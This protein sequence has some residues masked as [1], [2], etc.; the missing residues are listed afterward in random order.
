MM[1]RLM[2]TALAALCLGASV[3]PAMSIASETLQAS[4][5]VALNDLFAKQWVTAGSDGL[6]RGTVRELTGDG[7]RT[8]AKVD[9]AL[10][11][12]GNVAYSTK[13]D[14]DGAFAISSVAPGS[15]SLIARGE[16][17]L[18]AFSLQVL[19]PIA[20]KHLG[21]SIEVNTISPTGDSIKTILRAQVLPPYLNR[22]V[23]EEAR[24]I[25]DPLASSRTFAKSSVV[26]IDENGVLVGQLAKPASMKDIGDMAVFLTRDGREVAR[27][28]CDENGR[29]EVAGLTAGSY[30]LV[31][32]GD[33]GFAATAFH[34]VNPSMAAKSQQ[35]ERFVGLLH[36]QCC[37]AINVECIPTCDVVVCEQPVVETVVQSEIVQAPIVE[38]AVSEVCV[39]DCGMAPSCGCGGGGWGGGYF[40]GGGYGGGGG[41]FFGGGLGGLGAIIPLAFL[42]AIIDEIDDND[43]DD[44]NFNP[45]PV[46][47]A[48]R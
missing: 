8:L 29:F 15:Y 46:V 39:D 44:F 11:Q 10:V 27:T 2:R 25:H 41:G 22:M 21:N 37:P 19:D 42:P 6:I 38:P 48:I 17:K 4:S 3:S 16:G 28:V 32:A 20:G 23:V 12:E 7:S 14:A 26:Q 34:V 30:G 24:P 35:G 33:Q 18:A 1:K 13:S 36:H 5:S 45:P 47:S 9:V 40:G 43:N 31:A